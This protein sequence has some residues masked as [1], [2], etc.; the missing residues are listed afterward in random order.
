MA[1]LL[2]LLRELPDPVYAELRGMGLALGD[3]ATTE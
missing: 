3:R 1:T 2:G